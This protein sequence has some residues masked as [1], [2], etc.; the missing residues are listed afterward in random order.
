[1]FIKICTFICALQFLFA[2]DPPPW[3]QPNLL[4]SKRIELKFGSYGVDVLAQNPI[5]GYR[6]SSLYSEHEGKKIVRTLAFTQYETNMNDKLMAA[7]QEILAGASIGSTLK[8]HGF[9]IKKDLIY[10]GPSQDPMHIQEPPFAS[11]I[12]SLLA[13]EG[14]NYYPYCIILEVYSPEFLTLLEV[15]QIWNNFGQ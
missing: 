10:K 9:E 15:D 4:N 8:N 3:L 7:H 13:K 1:M 11:V 6:L 5:A 12:Y 14:D 2:E